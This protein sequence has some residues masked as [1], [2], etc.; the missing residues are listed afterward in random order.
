MGWAVKAVAKRLMERIDRIGAESEGGSELK[1]ALEL[2]IE[3]HAKLAV[4]LQ[5]YNAQDSWLADEAACESYVR[6]FNEGRAAARREML[7]LLTAESVDPVGDVRKSFALQ[8]GI[9]GGE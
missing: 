9:G 1:W 6:G 5:V 4:K 3:H 8:C 7:K 2:L